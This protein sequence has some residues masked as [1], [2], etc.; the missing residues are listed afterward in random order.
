[1]AGPR[2][3]PRRR[4]CGRRRSRAAWARSTAS[5]PRC[6]C[7]GRSRGSSGPRV[8]CTGCP[9]TSTVKVGVAS[10]RCGACVSSRRSTER[11]V[12]SGARSWGSVSVMRSVLGLRL[13]PGCTRR[14]GIRRARSAARTRPRKYRIP[15]SNGFGAQNSR[16]HSAAS[17]MSAASSSRICGSVGRDRPVVARRPISY[18]RRTPIRQGIVL[19][20]DSSDR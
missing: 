15:V 9:S 19:P 13:E 14:Q 8:R 4:T 20:H 18:I 10:G 12:A 2:P 1:M 5:A 17:R 16:P 7:R 11:S 3:R 6:R